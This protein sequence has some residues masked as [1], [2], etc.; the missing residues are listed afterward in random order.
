M[1]KQKQRSGCPAYILT[2]AAPIEN[3][4]DNVCLVHDAGLEQRYTDAGCH[5]SERRYQVKDQHKVFAVVCPEFREDRSGGGPIV[6]VPDFLVPGRPYPVYVYMYAIDLYSGAPEKGQRWAAEETRKHFGLETFAH[7]TLGR[8]M[9]AFGRGIGAYADAP[10]G[11]PD[12][13]E[14][15]GAKRGGLPTAQATAAPRGR[16]ALFLSGKLASGSREQFA[17]SCCDLARDWFAAH[18]RFLL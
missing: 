4:K 7:T 5:R 1:T 17:R 14:A 15:G 16:A 9:K 12:A 18:C 3:N 13:A 2:Q 6:I 10:D 8:A 11:R